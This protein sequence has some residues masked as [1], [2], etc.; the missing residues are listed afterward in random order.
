M[1]IFLTTRPS[2]F[3]GPNPEITLQESC[4]KCPW[5]SRHPT[6]FSATVACGQSIYNSSEIIITDQNPGQIL[7]K[8]GDFKSKFCNLTLTDGN[9]D[10]KTQIIQTEPDDF[11]F[12]HTDR[13]I[14]KPQDTIKF[15]VL[16]L[17][18]KS[19]PKSREVQIRVRDSK[20]NLIKLW[21]SSSTNNF[22]VFSDKLDLSDEPNLGEWKIQA[23][24]SKDKRTGKKFLVSEYV[25]PK[26]DADIYLPEYRVISDIQPILMLVRAR[27]NWGK[28]VNGTCKVD[29]SLWKKSCDENHSRNLTSVTFPIDGDASKEIRLNSRIIAKAKNGSKLEFRTTVTES[30][31]DASIVREKSVVLV[32]YEYQIR[33]VDKV[34]FNRWGLPFLVD[35]QILD[36]ENQLIKN[37]GD[38][39]TITHN[40]PGTAPSYTASVVDGVVQC[41]FTDAIDR[42]ESDHRFIE[43]TYKS[44]KYR[45]IPPEKK[46]FWGKP[47]SRHAILIDLV[48]SKN[49]ET[50]QTLKMLVKSTTELESVNWLV[51][52][53]HKI[54]S[55]G[56]KQN[57]RSKQFYLDIAFSKQDNFDQTVFVFTYIGAEFIGDFVSIPAES[58]L[59]YIRSSNLLELSISNDRVEPGGNVTISM[60]TKPNSTVYFRAIDQS[61]LLLAKDSDLS[62]DFLEQEYRSKKFKSGN[63]ERLDLRRSGIVVITNANPS[64]EHIL[65]YVRDPLEEICFVPLS[66]GNDVVAPENP[67]VEVAPRKYFPE[68]WLWEVVNID[69]SG[70]S[71]M[72]YPAPD[73]LTSWMITGYSLHPEHG[74]SILPSAKKLTTFKDFFITLELPYSVVQ[75]EQLILK[76]LVHN[77][78]PGNTTRSVSAQLKSTAYN[79]TINGDNVKQLKCPSK[80]VT[81]VSFVVTP[82]QIGQ[83]DLLVRAITTDAVDAVQKSLRVIPYGERV[84]VHAERW[85]EVHS[86]DIT[87]QNAGVLQEI[88]FPPGTTQVKIKTTGDGV[89]FAQLTHTYY[90][91]SDGINNASFETQ[92]SKPPPYKQF[93]KH[94]LKIT[95]INILHNKKNQPNEQ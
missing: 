83:I 15:R 95:S 18:R 17:D 30:G 26:F 59:T 85:Q 6:K 79:F 60:Q 24:L 45:Y 9:G 3:T 90:R 71:T 50:N 39:A 10:G 38:T 25:P 37:P 46:Y 21:K 36:R 40:F 22:G 77:Y 74:I 41:N 88:S 1:A 19:K 80:S 4:R 29:V 84:Q 35:F 7:L 61:V 48:S 56:K 5:A 34:S 47:I 75:D 93:L 82:H 2:N 73:S 32:L 20:N 11:V 66:G 89:I 62:Q 12:I 63:E 55:A 65:K 64:D 49:V 33:P 72:D 86:V 8:I 27:S 23:S 81:S 16:V 92:I 94:C 54:V 28:F 52:S 78:L 68:T 70:N 67:S 43:I 91:R 58:N 53:N 13:P 14:Y 31:S 57:Q 42:S 87:K 44:L 51:V 76:I 69:R